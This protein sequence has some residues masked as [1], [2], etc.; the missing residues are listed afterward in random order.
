MI[1]SN[2][3]LAAAY[4]DPEASLVHIVCISL[5]NAVLIDYGLKLVEMSL[6]YLYT[7]SSNLIELL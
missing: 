4:T 1:Y 3:P 5:N 6:V 2:N 7:I